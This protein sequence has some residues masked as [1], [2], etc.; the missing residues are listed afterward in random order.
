M[1]LPVLLALFPPSICL[2]LTMVAAHSMYTAYKGKCI[3]LTYD[4]SSHCSQSRLL[5]LVHK[6]CPWLDLS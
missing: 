3:Y 6:F 5:Q 2:F 4:N 1:L